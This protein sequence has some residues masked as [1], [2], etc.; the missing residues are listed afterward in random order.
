MTLRENIDS[1]GKVMPLIQ[2]KG[3]TFVQ[4]YHLVAKCHQLTPK[5]FVETNRKNG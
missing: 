5:K 1:K 3:K 4:N 2:F